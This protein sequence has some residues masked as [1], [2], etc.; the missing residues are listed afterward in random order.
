MNLFKAVL[1]INLCLLAACQGPA[2]SPAAEEEPIDQ[3]KN[4]AVATQDPALDTR[5]ASLVGQSSKCPPDSTPFNLAPWLGADITIACGL[6]SER[7]YVNQ[8]GIPRLQ[9][10]YEYTA[11][12]AQEELDALGSALKA[13]GFSE[14]VGSDAQ[15]NQRVYLKQGLDNV[16]VWANPVRKPDFKDPQANGAIGIDM[17]D[18]A[19]STP[20]ASPN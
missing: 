19:P 6:R 17:S 16:N 2:M 9:I 14:K 11:G 1:V 8:A 7:K 15:A 12:T 20:T 13:A 3:S 10:T 5:P 4:G 18:I